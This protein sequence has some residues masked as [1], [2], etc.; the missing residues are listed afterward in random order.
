MEPPNLPGIQLTSPPGHVAT[1]QDAFHEPRPQIWVVSWF[2]YKPNK[3][4]QA[5]LGQEDTEVFPS[6]CVF[7]FPGE[8]P[9]APN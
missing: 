2:R 1:A 5:T 4:T 6:V 7:F 9:M 8:G 3:G